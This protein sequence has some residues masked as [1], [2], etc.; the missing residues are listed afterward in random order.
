[1]SVRVITLGKEGLV[2]DVD[3]SI[4]YVMCCFFFSKFSQSTLYS[5]KVTSLTKIIQLYGDDPVMIRKEIEAEL[6]KFLGRYYTTVTVEVTIE[7]SGDDPSINLLIN[8]I[9]SNG[10][11]ISPNSTSV[12]YS[13]ATKN[14]ILK[15]IVDVTNGDT[16][17]SF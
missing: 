7:D 5:G 13:L 16:I 3:R 2:S 15:S 17:Y 9:V 12:G 1:M 14:S 4:D 10:D 11:S 8:A 6:Q